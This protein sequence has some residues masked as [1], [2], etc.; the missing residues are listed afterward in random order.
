[1]GLDVVICSD[2]LPANRRLAGEIENIAT[3]CAKRC[4]PHADAGSKALPH[5]Q[6][7]ARPPQGHTFREKPRRKAV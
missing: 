5:Y 3:G 7:D 4:P 6:P 2:D 1:M